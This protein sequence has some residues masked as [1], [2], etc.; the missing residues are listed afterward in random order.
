MLGVAGNPRDRAYLA[1][2]IN[3][4][5]RANEIS[6]LRVG[7]VDLERGVHKLGDSSTLWEDSRTWSGLRPCM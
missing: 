7:D 5:L 2:T 4:G 3:T 6:R 1:T